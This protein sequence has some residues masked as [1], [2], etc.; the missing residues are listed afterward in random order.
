MMR[1][2]TFTFAIAVVTMVASTTLLWSRPHTI[3]SATATMPSIAELN[4]TAGASRL[5]VQEISDQSLI[6]PLETRQ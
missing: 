6:F 4:A 2:I 1:W 5:P 3:V